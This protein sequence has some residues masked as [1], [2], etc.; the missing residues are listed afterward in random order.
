M[1]YSL[2]IRS[3]LVKV[4]KILNNC[5]KIIKISETIKTFAFL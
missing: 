2:K 4:Y 3:Y 1:F 5:F